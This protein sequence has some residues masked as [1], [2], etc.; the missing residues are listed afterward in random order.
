MSSKIVA[1]GIPDVKIITPI[2]HQD[3]RGFF[4]EVYN[5]R[6]FAEAG[7]EL[8]FVQDNVS[9]SANKRTVRGLHFQKPPYAQD[10]L[11]YVVKGAIFDVA[12]D[13]RNDSPTLGKHVAAIITA[14]AGNQIFVPIGFAHGFCALDPNTAVVYKVTNYYAPAHQGGLLW[15][16][17][18]LAIDWPVSE[19]EAMLSEQDRAQPRFSEL[20]RSLTF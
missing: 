16:D 10:K 13:L 18:E 5:K 11:V 19:D 3:Q 6:V 20:I 1:T 8:E 15:N 12:V 2:R 17:P 4:T 14:E 9:F 7:I